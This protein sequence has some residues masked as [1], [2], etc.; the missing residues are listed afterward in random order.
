MQRKKMP[1]FTLRTILSISAVLLAI[2]TTI[3]LTAVSEEIVTDFLERRI[4]LQLASRSAELADKLDRILYERYKEIVFYGRDLAELGLLNQ[5]AAVRDRLDKLHAASQGYAWIGLARRDGNIVAATQGILEGIDIS[6]RLWFRQAQ[7][8]AFVGDVHKALLLEKKLNAGGSEPLRFL[9]VAVPV[10]DRTGEFAGVLGAHIDWRWVQSIRSVNLQN[11]HS[12][13]LL[14]GANNTVLLGPADLQD[15]PL[16]IK[17]VQ[18]ASKGANGYLIERWPDGKTYVTGYS[19]SSGYREYP[20]LGWTILERQELT[21]AFASVQVLRQKLFASGI[22]IAAIFALIGWFFAARIARPINAITEAAESLQR[23]VKKEIPVFK[24][25]RETTVLAHTL[26]RL[27]AELTGRESELA[28]QATHHPLTQLP[29]RAL[30]KTLIDQ[31]IARC[32][33]GQGHVAVLS[34]NLDRF[35]RVNQTHGHDAGDAIIREAAQRLAACLGP[36]GTL[37]HLGD[38]KFVML[39]EDHDAELLQT[40]RLAPLALEGLIKPYQ[41]KEAEFFLTANV[42]ISV[43]PNDGHDAETLLSRSALALFHARQL[44]G[45]CVEFFHEQ[46]NAAVQARTDLERDLRQAIENRQFALH[47]QPQMS[48]TTGAIVGVEALLRWHHP[49][50]GLISPADFIPVAESSGL[51]IPIGDWVLNEACAQAISWQKMGLPPIRM[52][53]NVSVQQFNAGNLVQ[54]VA[55]ALQKTQLH[56]GLLKLEI[57]ESLLMQE[58]EQSIETMNRLTEL[59]VHL[60]IDDFGTGYSS[61][62]YLK[63]FPISELKI[64]RAFV[65]EL[66]PGSSDA[67]IVRAIIALGH[68]LGLDIIAEGVETAEQHDFLQAEQC[69]QIQ[70]YYFS[71]PVPAENIAYLLAPAVPV[72]AGP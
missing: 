59:G 47:Y 23:G 21:D 61:L 51:I 20:G 6:E 22:I 63:R 44:T 10:T 11:K 30:L 70:G 5:P 7:K 33:H 17:S 66:T 49:E 42:G 69:D 8:S 72:N 65:R 31:A 3:G 34:F 15:K 14:I 57:T 25:Y 38:D 26:R 56:P 39:L 53:I 4:G 68:N 36:G 46:M 54:R 64:D 37:G 71:R 19:K 50:R 1:R 12:E 48:L 13:A 43:H 62:A 52:G 55:A 2:T 58:I 67:A 18:R 16:T 28:H 60:A 40:H 41:V 27:I 9:D 35:N 29:N 24:G 32:R 45:N